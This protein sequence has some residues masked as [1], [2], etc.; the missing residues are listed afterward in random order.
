MHRVK[1]PASGG[2]GFSFSRGIKAIPQTVETEPKVK[3]I[4]QTKY[5]DVFEP[6][7]AG[8]SLKKNI[9]EK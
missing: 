6:N 7:T 5:S 4:R 3:T 8:G 9:K 2:G 1:R